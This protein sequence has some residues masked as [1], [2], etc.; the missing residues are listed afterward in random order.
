MAPLLQQNR[1][2]YLTGT[3]V[4]TENNSI[5]QLGFGL[6]QKLQRHAFLLRLIILLEPLVNTIPTYLT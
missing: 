3:I 4:R 6:F 2:Y 5:R 1:Y